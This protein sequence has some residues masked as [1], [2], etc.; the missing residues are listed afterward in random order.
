MADA[1]LTAADKYDLE[2]LKVMCEDALCRDLFVENAAHTLFLA[3]LHSREQLRIQAQVSLQLML[4][5]CWKIMVG[6]YPDLMAEA[7][8]SVS[9]AQGLFLESPLKSL[10]QS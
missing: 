6:S 10:K 5:R 9:S 4:L 2:G 7:Y 8:G 3:D 1:M